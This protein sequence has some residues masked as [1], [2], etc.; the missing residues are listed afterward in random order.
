MKKSYMLVGVVGS[1]LAFGTQAGAA[2]AELLARIEKLEAELKLLKQ[3]IAVSE[4]PG[5]TA[6][7][8]QAEAPVV[9]ASAKDGFSIRSQDSSAKLKIGGYIQAEGK[10]FTDNKKDIGTTDTFQDRTIRLQTSGTVASNF[11]FFISPEFAGTSVN[12]PDAYFDVR[13]RP[14]FNL[15]VGKFKEPFGLERLQSTIY[16]VFAEQG[17]PTNL[18]PNRDAGAQIYGDLMDG[19]VQYAVG[20][21]NGVEDLGSSIT[22]GNQDKDIAGRI[23]VTPFKTTD[24]IALRGLG[25]GI[26]AT[27]GHREGTTGA[28]PTY[29]SSSQTSVFS[30][31]T[32][33]SADGALNRLSPQF[34]YGAGPLGILGEY[35]VSSET[36]ARTASGS[37][38][39]ERVSN[40]AWQLA[41]S[42][43]LTGEDASYK[44]VVPARPFDWAAGQWGAFE[45]GGRYGELEIDN[46]AFD[47]GFASTNS[48]I[49]R[50]AAYGA[51]LNWYLNRNFRALIAY[52]RTDFDGG[53]I[54][55]DRA[56]ENV[57][58]SRLQIVF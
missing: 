35:I 8:K 45:V 20:A 9:T 52:E 22:D 36:L 56:S 17:L 30:Y 19:R 21:F 33:V 1:M 7:S 55:T 44:G 43:V 31:N 54:G 34:Y 27:Y 25:A 6:Q 49:S 11:D 42:Y 3:Q 5:A 38:V 28:L 26:A 53:S 41:A 47:L 57:L 39:R 10:F 2:D 12:I 50:A 58:W 32:G 51:V 13:M 29:R 40:D 14:E 37:L 18:G 24:V 4:A 15:R 48:A 23:F 16:H 46:S